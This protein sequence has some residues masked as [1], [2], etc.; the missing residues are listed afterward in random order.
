MNLPIYPSYDKM[1][2]KIQTTEHDQHA[3]DNLE[4]TW[5][6]QGHLSILF[7]KVASQVQC[8]SI[9]IMTFSLWFL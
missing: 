2:F 3:N 6:A 7:A 9:I 1:W 4:V 5:F 8:L